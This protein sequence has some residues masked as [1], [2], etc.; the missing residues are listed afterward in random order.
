[1]RPLTIA[2]ADPVD[3]QMH[4]IYSDGTWTPDGLMAYLGEQ[5]FRAVAITDHDN[6]EGIS[7]VVAAGAMYGVHVIPAVEVTTTWGEYKA[8]LLCFAERFS[9]DALPALITGTRLR[10]LENT[11]EVHDELQRRGYAFPRQAEVLAERGG[12]LF[13]PTDNIALLRAHGYTSTFAQG[14]ALITEA[15][16]R[17]ISVALGDAINAAHASGAVALLAHPGRGEP[18]FTAYD[19]QALDEVRASTALD[20]IEVWHPSHASRQV[21]EFEAYTARYNWLRSAGSDSH[22]PGGRLPIPYRAE[23]VRSLLARCG[24]DVAG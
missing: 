6:L 7:A 12:E 17:E 23:Q 13:R 24:V 9:S 3:L 8:D 15:G 11:H 16:F 2:S 4:T 14:P 10:Q 1:M 5:G 18:P 20:G 21:A 19:L 22:G